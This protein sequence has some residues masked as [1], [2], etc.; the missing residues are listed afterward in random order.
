MSVSF[1][2][3]GLSDP[4]SLVQGRYSDNTQFYKSEQFDEIVEYAD[5]VTIRCTSTDDLFAGLAVVQSVNDARGDIWGKNIR[6]LVLPYIPGARQDRFNRT[7]D[8]SS[9]LKTVGRLINQFDFF[10]VV[11]VDPHSEKA[12]YYINSLVEYPKRDLYGHLWKG[13]GGVIAPDKGAFLR[14]VEAAT[15][16]G[17]DKEMKFGSKVRDVS[18]GR[19]TGF[20]VDDLTEG[21]HYVVVDDICDGGG[22]FVGLGEKIAEQGAF[23]DLFVTHGFF[24]KGL[25]DIRKYYKNVYTTNT[26][27]RHFPMGGDGQYVFRIVEEMENYNV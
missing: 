7:G 21:M 19:L 10:N 25:R 17:K 2:G 15:A 14:G 1:R 26:V 3:P 22:T 18:N 8:V 16:L 12:G 5:S 24:T 4:I 13:Y 23:A 6:N 27:D 20:D 11:V 9:T